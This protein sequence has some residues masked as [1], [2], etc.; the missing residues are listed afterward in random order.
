M[1]S[2]LK[3]FLPSEKSVFGAKEALFKLNVEPLSFLCDLFILNYGEPIWVS[4]EIL[5]VPAP[6][7]AGAVLV[8]ID[9]L[10]FKVDQAPPPYWLELDYLSKLL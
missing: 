9:I 4:L 6:L 5:P 1:V 10:E 3:E 8:S 7:S 2:L